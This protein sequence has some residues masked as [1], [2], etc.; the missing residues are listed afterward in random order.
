[1]CVKQQA[2]VQVAE[3]NFCKGSTALTW[4]AITASAVPVCRHRVMDNK[5]ER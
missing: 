2:K 1:M 4:K 3:R 5:A